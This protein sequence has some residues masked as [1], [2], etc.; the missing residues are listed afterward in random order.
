MLLSIV[1]L[2]RL[3]ICVVCLVFEFWDCG[4]CLSC[5]Q[6]LAKRIEYRVSLS[7]KAILNKPNESVEGRFSILFGDEWWELI[8]VLVFDFVGRFS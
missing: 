6:R 1:D 4:L 3:K 7:L 5:L 8:L 2:V